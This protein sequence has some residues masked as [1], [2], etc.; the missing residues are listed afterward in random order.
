[1]K[2]WFYFLSALVLLILPTGCGPSS[3]HNVIT[4]VKDVKEHSL[5]VATGTVQ[6]L[7]AYK[8]FS[9]ADIRQI[10][11]EPDVYYAVQSG[12]VDAGMVS[13]ISLAMVRHQF[14][15]IYCIT[16]TL[17][18]LPCSFA[19]SKK[20]PELRDKLNAYLEECIQSGEFKKIYDDWSDPQ[21][22]R[23]M[24]EIDPSQCPNG[25]L[26]TATPAIGPPFTMMKD[27]KVS[28]IEAE[29]MVRFASQIGMNLEIQV[30]ELPAVIASIAS[31]KCDIGFC[32]FCITEERSKQVD[33]A[34]PYIYES[35]A[36][37]VNS[38][39]QPQEGIEG[40]T[41]NTSFW[42]QMKESFTR[43]VI[44]EDR[45]MLL[46]E[47]LQQTLLIVIF[48]AIVGTLWGM[49]LCYLYMHRNRWLYHT[50][51]L[52]I[53]FMRCMPQMVFLMIMFYIVFGSTN[54][55][56]TIVAIIAF[57]LCFGAY[58]AVI[59]RTVVESLDR[60][61]TEA[62]LS[63]GFTKV[64]TFLHVI[65]PQAVQR[66]LPIYKSEFI[67]LIKATSIVGY[68]AVFD[69]TKAGDMIR[70][71][72]YEPFF[73]LLLITLIYFLII[74]ILSWALKYAETKTKPKRRKF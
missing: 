47:G 73:P 31:G 72:T 21:T 18:Q 50:A 14:P 11:S 51:S 7:A 65:L 1:M 39:F 38:K 33:F 3:Q 43:N 2:K 4:E 58:T 61:Q 23:S 56:S 49:I 5:M 45:Y 52:Y 67:G 54:I 9:E 8:L 69:L 40:T 34:I 30:M 48:S 24:P 64:Q 28:G 25:T 55:S 19:V 71:R 74:W 62:S 46:L 12:K 32:C 70:S 13:A 60:G 20:K 17:N 26:V 10:T 36:L 16:D 27:N 29:L 59:F 53:D 42:T 44:A 66:A 68:I 6:E 22:T 37:I 63:M 57:A 15:D 35:S 41:T